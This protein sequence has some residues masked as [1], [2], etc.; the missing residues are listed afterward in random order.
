MILTI[1]AS[2]EDHYLSKV[3]NL[4]NYFYSN[5]LVPLAVYPFKTL[6]YIHTHVQFL[7]LSLI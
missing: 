5:G 3:N 7:S 2:R 6:E 1:A 4:C